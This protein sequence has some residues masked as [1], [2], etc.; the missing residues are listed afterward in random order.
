MIE[1]ATRYSYSGIPKSLSFSGHFTWYAVIVNINI[2]PISWALCFHDP[3]L[4]IRRRI[5][6]FSGLA[7]ASKVYYGRIPTEF[8]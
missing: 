3:V 2:L 4:T 1:P 6:A 8:D 5:S 7:A